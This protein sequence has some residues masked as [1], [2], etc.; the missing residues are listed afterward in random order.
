M[1]AMNYHDFPIDQPIE[2]I[3]KNYAGIDLHQE[4]LESALHLLN[5]SYE[6]ARSRLSPT[7]APLGNLKLQVKYSYLRKEVVAFFGTS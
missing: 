2:V 7:T 5:Q 3:V 4:T 6:V 1:S